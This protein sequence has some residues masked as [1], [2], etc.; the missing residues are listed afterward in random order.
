MMPSNAA[1]LGLTLSDIMAPIM[2]KSVKALS[3]ALLI[4]V[5]GPAFVQAAEPLK[6]NGGYLTGG[7]AVAAAA[8]DQAL[9]Q[10]TPPPPTPQELKDVAVNQ[11]LMS[12]AADSIRGSA[13]QAIV[14]TPPVTPVPAKPVVVAKKNIEIKAALDKADDWIQKHL[15]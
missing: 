14:V 15:W 11:A 7:P 8:V 12:F 6:G 3:M 13:P 2:E 5:S 9:E 4:V 10:N 1:W